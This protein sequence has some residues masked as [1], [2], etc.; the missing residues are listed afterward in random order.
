MAC[1]S[2][3]SVNQKAYPS[4]INIHPPHS[5]QNL[6]KPTLMAFPT[7]LIC[8]NCGYTEFA[9]AERERLELLRNNDDHWKS[10]PTALVKPKR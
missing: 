9:L 10:R 1:K 4:E 7:L 3:H 2:C 8:L 5:L 6:D